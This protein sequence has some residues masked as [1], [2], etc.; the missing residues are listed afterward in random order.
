M[1]E[2]QRR[3]DVALGLAPDLQL[4]PLISHRVPLEHAADAYT[5]VDQH[6]E[7]TIQVVLTYGV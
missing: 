6:A 7:E 3:L 1:G 4:E 5:L 2:K